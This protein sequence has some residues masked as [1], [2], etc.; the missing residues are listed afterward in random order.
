MCTHIVLRKIDQFLSTINQITHVLLFLHAKGQNGS[1]HDVRPT[2]LVPFMKWVIWHVPKIP[3]FF[4]WYSRAQHICL[5]VYVG[6]TPIPG[7][8]QTVSDLSLPY[9]ASRSGIPEQVRNFGS[10]DVRP[11][12]FC[13]RLVRPKESTLTSAELVDKKFHIYST[14]CPSTLKNPYAYIKFNYCFL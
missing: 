12:D 4:W 5:Q 7:C 3:W 11:G 8:C 2:V 13:S 6:W 9:L 14:V 10:R 1:N